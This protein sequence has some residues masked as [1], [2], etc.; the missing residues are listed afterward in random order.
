MSLV[1]NSTGSFPLTIGLHPLAVLSISDFYTRAHLSRTLLIGGLLGK[2]TGRDLSIEQAYEFRIRDDQIDEE[3]FERK[4]EQYKTNFRD[5]DFLGW[6]YVPLEAPFEPTAAVL[7]IQTRLTELLDSPPLLLILNAPAVAGAAAGSLPIKIYEPVVVEGGRTAF[8]EAAH[9]IESGEA[10]HIAVL[11]VAD[12]GKTDAA[13][14][15]KVSSLLA[16]KASAAT[17][18]L[19]RLRLV[20]AYLEHARAKPERA[21]TA[22]DDEIVRAVGA[23]LGRLGSAVG[24]L[25]ELAL[26]QQ[27]DALL[28][29]LLGVVTRGLKLS[30][31]VGAK[32]Q[33][34]DALRDDYKRYR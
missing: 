22:A 26:A 30:S 10:E 4:L 5:H 19:Q 7:P 24:N 11:H 2:Q 12:E 31:D 18:L 3:Y 8:V 33:V 28:A 13:A 34:L 21:L 25:D 15:D 1:I 23:L 29:A 16:S 32:R 27:V 14:G 20:R 9:R 17:M 6:F